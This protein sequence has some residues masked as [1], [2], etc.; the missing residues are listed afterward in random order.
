MTDAITTGFTPEDAQAFLRHFGKKGMKW[1]VTNAAGS[2]PTSNRAHLKTLDKN[3]KA[4]DRAEY[5]AAVKKLNKEF[6]NDIDTSR[7]RVKSGTAKAE[8][9]AAK[10]TYKQEKMIKGKYEAKKALREAE[11]KY[12]TDI[13]ISKTAKSGKEATTVALV[14]VG[15][16]VVGTAMQ[17]A[18]S[19]R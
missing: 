2:A 15:L 13:A 8:Y 1:G 3:A 6:D 19:G 16:L 4:K 10:E 14:A 9:K 5:S 12:I 18:A 17:A 7:A 11:D